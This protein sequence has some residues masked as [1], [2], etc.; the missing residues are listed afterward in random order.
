MFPT[1]LAS[2]LLPVYHAAGVP[3]IAGVPTVDNIPLTRV[4]TSFRILL[5]LMF[6]AVP[7]LS[8]AAVDPADLVNLTTVNVPGIYCCGSESGSGSFGSTRFWPPGS[9]SFYHHA[10]IVRKTLIPNIL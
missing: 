3:A 5:L 8:C 10:K 2:L 6:P 4:S 1:F 9:G 7:I